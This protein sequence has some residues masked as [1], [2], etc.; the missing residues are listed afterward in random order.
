[1][2]AM[3]K[4]AGKMN[5]GVAVSLIGWVVMAYAILHFGTSSDIVQIGTLVLGFGML[6]VGI[7]LMIWAEH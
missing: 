3:V 4:R 6:E 1:M 7:A 5:G 2:I